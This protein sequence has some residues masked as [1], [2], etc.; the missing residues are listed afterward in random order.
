MRVDV[1]LPSMLRPI[2]GGESSLPVDLD[3]PATL[4]GV[5]D[6]LRERYPAL[7]RRLRDE[8]GTLRRYVNFY[9]DGE[10]CRRLDGAGTALRDGA[11]VV[12][13]PSVAGG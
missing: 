3:G 8:R 1:R 4:G 12:V 9:V 13:I 11:E 2:V 6:R 10:E 7:E 5:L